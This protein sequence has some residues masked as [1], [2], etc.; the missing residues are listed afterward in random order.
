MTAVVPAPTGALARAEGPLLLAHRGDH[1]QATENSLAAFHAA[2]AVP[3]CGGLEFDV[4]ASADGVA[5]VIHD[6]TL[7]RVQRRPD[8]VHTMWTADL[9]A[10]GVPTLAAVL[11]AAPPPAFLDIELKEPVAAEAV[12]DIRAAR[13]DPPPGV[14]VS[15]FDPRVLRDVRELAPGWPLWLN[16]ADLGRRTIAT[17]VDLGCVGISAQ[18]RAVSESSIARA[19]AA[20]LEIAAWTVTRRPTAARLAALGVVA[21]CVEGHALDPRR[22]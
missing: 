10:L 12:A 15:S 21:L 1:R 20:G 22:G 6:D 19:R 3:G 4:R 8:S 16:A 13:S 2:L 9:E 11:E 5:V 18:W 14:V 7:R 17:A